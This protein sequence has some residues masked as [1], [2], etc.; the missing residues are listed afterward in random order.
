MIG[1]LMAGFRH[2]LF[3]VDFSGRCAAVRPF[4][5]T[6]ATPCVSKLT[7]L[8]VFDKPAEWYGASECTTQAVFDVAQMKE[9]SCAMLGDF[10]PQ[11]ADCPFEISREARCGEDVPSTIV[12]FAEEHGVDLIMMPTH[13]RG[14]FQ[15][16]LL[17]ST[18][19]SIL[20]ASP[21]PVWTAAH[22]ED[23]A[24]PNHANC[25]NVVVAAE[26]RQSKLTEWALEIGSAFAGE[27]CLNVL[28]GTKHQTREVVQAARDKNADLLILGLA[29]E[30]ASDIVRQARCPVLTL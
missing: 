10:L 7:L 26:P 12:Q 21:C 15:R 14:K 22:T 28:E 24:L 3:P 18:T 20:E 17:G 23:P 2:I 27:A 6:L 19:S 25:R 5:R 30:R 1:G 16:L 8:H 11:N 9:E 29:R 13:G 4:V